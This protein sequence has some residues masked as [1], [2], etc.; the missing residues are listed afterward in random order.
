MKQIQEMQVLL[1]FSIISY[2]KSVLCRPMLQ[3]LSLPEIPTRRTG[4][5][6][7]TCRS[8]A[9][10]PRQLLIALRVQTVC[11]VGAL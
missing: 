1:C 3:D 4:A 7:G 5:D 9:A 8:T 11:S 10:G 2:G 6:L